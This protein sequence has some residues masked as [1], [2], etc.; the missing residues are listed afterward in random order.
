MYLVDALLPV[1]GTGDEALVLQYDDGNAVDEQHRVSPDRLS[2]LHHELVR[3][4]EVVDV[5]V[6][7]GVL[8]ESDRGG[9]LSV[10]QY[11]GHPVA[12]R[13]ERPAVG[14]QTVRFSETAP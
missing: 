10:L 2:S 6:F 13:V 1:L 7:D 14:R 5:L 8:D 4:S 3:H 12:E 9:R 11:H